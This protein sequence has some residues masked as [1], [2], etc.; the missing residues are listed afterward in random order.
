M[1]E[2]LKIRNVEELQLAVDKIRDRGWA[3]GFRW[4]LLLEP[5]SR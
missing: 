1:T 2:I 4:A 3:I 5:P